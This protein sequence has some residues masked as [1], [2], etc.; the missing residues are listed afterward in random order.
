[1]KI[2]KYYRKRNQIELNKNQPNERLLSESEADRK[3]IAIM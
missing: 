1:M 2:R 3:I